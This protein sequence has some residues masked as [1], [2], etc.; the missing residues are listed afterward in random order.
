[1]KN[2][3]LKQLA[4][5]DPI[6]PVWPE[7][8]AA[9]GYEESLVEGILASTEPDSDPPRSS[10]FRGRTS[11]IGVAIAAVCVIAFA[12][13]LSVTGTEYQESSAWG[14]ELVEFAEASPLVLLDLPDWNVSYVNEQSKTYGDMEFVTS[15]VT[16]PRTFPKIQAELTWRGGS[17]SRR[18]ARIDVSSRE[19]ASG[20][21]VLGTETK[22]FEAGRTK[23]SLVLRSAWDFEGRVLELRS[24]VPS[25]AE[26]KKILAGFKRVD[27][28][29]WLE[30]LPASV[31][32]TFDRSV[33]VNRMLESVP[34]PPGFDPSVIPGKNLTKNEYQLGTSVAGVVACT[35]VDRWSDARRSGDQEGA[36]EAIRAMSTA[37]EW[38]VLLKMAKSGGYPQVVWQFAAAMAEGPTFFGR[39]LEFDASTG[40]GCAD[41]GVDLTIPEPWASRVR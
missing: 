19:V 39:P 36:R 31:V 18:E 26:Y 11:R 20:V 25:L 9:S 12:A 33:A 17:A 1:M 27:V 4:E 35:W 2:D 41:L 30:G 23:A 37:R 40:L 38:P 10:R 7:I 32:N 22:I 29:T 14:S 16:G 6:A 28:D 5:A 34:L 24:I 8:S 15:P 13:I 21:P 3:V